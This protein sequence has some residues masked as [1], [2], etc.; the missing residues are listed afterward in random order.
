[1]T[2]EYASGLAALLIS[3][4]CLVLVLIAAPEHH[5]WTAL[6]WAIVMI[7]TTIGML[8]ARAWIMAW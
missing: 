4:M 1:M 8:S 5:H 6:N 3:S 7:L 2:W